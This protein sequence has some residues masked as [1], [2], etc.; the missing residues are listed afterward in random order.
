MINN[1]NK[2]LFILSAIAVAAA[3][4]FSAL[5]VYA[6][7][8]ANRARAQLALGQ[9]YLADMEYDKAIL[10]FE[11]AEAIM[12]KTEGLP[13]ICSQKASRAIMTRCSISFSCWC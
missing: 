11:N 2:T 10:Q 6:Q 9:K 13:S 4:A 1:K 7:T 5:Y 8:P 12:P 3:I